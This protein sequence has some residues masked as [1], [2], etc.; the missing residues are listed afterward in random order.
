MG[1]LKRGQPV[2]PSE[3]YFRG[4]VRFET[5]APDLHWLTRHI[6][7]ATGRRFPKHVEIGV[8]QVL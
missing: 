5:A 2:D 4:A 7:I 6:F 1:R 3:I 8:F